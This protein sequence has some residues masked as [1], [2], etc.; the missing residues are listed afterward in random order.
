MLDDSRGY[1]Q[2]TI[3]AFGSNGS[4]QLGIGHTEDVSAPCVIAGGHE[5]TNASVTDIVAG[6]NHTVFLFDDGQIATTGEN[7]DGRCLTSEM[8][9]KQSSLRFP[10]LP[11]MGE[12]QHIAATWSATVIVN[13]AGNVF[14]RGS[15]E[16]GELGLG[17]GTT[18][19]EMLTLIN[20]FPPPGTTIVKMSACMAHAVIVLSN[21]EVWGWGRGRKGQL[22]HPSSIV[23]KPR[24]IDGIEFFAVDAICG[25]EFTCI[26]GSRSAG[27]LLVLG[28]N[29]NDRFGVKSD[30]P[31]VITCWKQATASWGSI[32]ILLDSGEVLSWGRNDH[33]Q[34]PPSHLPSLESIAAGSEHCLGI[35]KDGRVL[36]WGWGEHGNCG[37]PTDQLGNVEA[38][39]NEI[40]LSRS[41]SAVS[42]GCATSFI[43][44]TEP[45]FSKRQELTETF[46]TGVNTVLGR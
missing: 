41:A 39:W 21:G 6:G 29:S 11:N 37:Q 40:E 9:H 13:R 32:F 1:S 17:D 19:A 34:L 44:A 24:K 46:E 5:S 31:N 7:G 3:Y 20:D 43:V 16:S 35:T 25:K 10:S 23:W 30:A 36:A 28:L 26:L 12:I 38:R 22:G 27:S 4:G 2:I 14:V 33:G 8:N 45:Y 42:A 15:G 18:L